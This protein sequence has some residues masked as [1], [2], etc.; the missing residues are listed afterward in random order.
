MV[1]REARRCIFYLPYRLEETGQGARMVRPRKMIRAF[2]NIGYAVAVIE[3]FSRER[4][5][6]IREIR[7][8][9]RRGVRFDFLYMEASTEPIL[10]TD[11]GHLPLHPRMDF[12]FL[13]TV[14]KHGI[15]VGL[16][17]SD[18]FWKY[19]GY[20]AGLPKWKKTCALACY[21]AE[22]RGYEKWTDR[23]YV[24]EKQTFSEK[25]GSGVLSGK[26]AELPPGAENLP[27]PDRNGRDFRSRPLT[28]FYVGGLGGNYQIGEM[29]KAAGTENVRLILCC[30][31]AEW[32]KEKETL[33]PLMGERT[34]VIHRCGE[35]LEPFYQEAD[36]GMLLF[37]RGAYMD[38]AKPLKAY[39]YLAHELP[40]LATRGTAMGDF[41]AEKGIGWSVDFDADS[42]AAVLREILARPEMLR[43]KQEACAAAKR[44]NLW[45]R[46]A[47]TVAEGLVRGQGLGIRD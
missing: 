10:L 47:E 8:E 41:A 25:L 42:I 4:K 26:M 39:E 37:R 35:E 46:R 24:P 14:R 34:E 3:G 44:E 31:E 28:L 32:E 16:F 23:F 7:D 38:M 17:Y 1:N 18:L 5:K 12:G 27:S 9:I 19:D 29:L 21:R 13:K 11:P 40:V 2:E 22:L 33:L 30:R 36:L 15:P 43:E 6:R 20:G 45:E